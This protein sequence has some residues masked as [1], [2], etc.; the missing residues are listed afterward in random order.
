MWKRICRINGD[1]GLECRGKAGIQRGRGNSQTP[2][3][4]PDGGKEMYLGGS[5][6]NP[7]FTQRLYV[8]G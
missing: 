4:A 6:V 2:A 7:L 8:K 5:Y 1:G 3:R